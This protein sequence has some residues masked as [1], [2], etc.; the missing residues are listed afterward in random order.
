MHPRYLAL[1]LVS[2]GVT[3]AQLT[4]DQKIIDFQQTVGLYVKN[5]GPYE[6]KQRLYG[7]DLLDTGKWLDRI[8]ATKDDLEYYQVMSE[9]VAQLNDAHDRFTLPSNFQGLL[10]F[11]VDIYDGKLLVDSINRTR[12]P[13]SQYPFVIGYEL[14]SIDGQDATA[15]LNRMVGYSV[16]ANERSTRRLAAELITFRPQQVIPDAPNVPEISVVVFRRFDG[17]TETYRIP[18]TK[19]GVP[20]TS[21]GKFPAFRPARTQPARI[22]NDKLQTDE[23]QPDYLRPI[24]RLQNLRIP[25]RAVLNWGG[26]QPIFIGAMPPGFTQRLG[27]LPTEF[28]FSG[29]FEA[30]GYRIG[31]I[32]IPNFG[33]L[34]QIEALQQFAREIAFFNENTDGL[35]IDEMRNPGGFVNYTNTLLSYLIW[36]PWTSLGLSVRATSSW[37]QAFSLTYESAKAQGAPEQIVN[38]LAAAKQELVEANAANRGLSDPVSVDAPFTLE[39]QPAR[40][41]NGA[42]LAY[43]K[44]LMVLID[45]FSASGGDAFAAMIQDNGRGI[46]F[47]RRTMGAG[48]NVTAWIAGT[49][50]DGVSSLTESLLV[51]K[52]ERAEAG[53]YPVSPYIENVGVHPDI[54]AD[55]MTFENLIQRGRPFVSA[56]T[57]AMVDHITRTK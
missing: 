15:I 21:V 40:S 25:D 6:W 49:Y 55:I 47:G 22:D 52:Y 19:T 4:M 30:G 53:G 33:P 48:G 44:P 13:A 5:Y 35:I 23:N 42:L 11:F 36:Y 37:V 54:E 50:S 1:L 56:F 2:A 10:N 28:F 8:R 18:W 7:V 17:N 12:L 43:T 29:T 31:F 26:L 41:Q 14:V 32:R 9:W 39:R 27:R 3:S 46:L 45:E 34:N 20:L 16:A 38:A 24:A 57:A 51:R